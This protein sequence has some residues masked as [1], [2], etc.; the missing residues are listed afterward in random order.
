V[1][2]DVCLQ[3]RRV[4]ISNFM[5]W[6]ISISVQ[7]GLEDDLLN[8]SSRSRSLMTETSCRVYKLY[9]VK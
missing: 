5:N 1:C 3:V 7:D 9:Q 8:T 4:M 6:H 2:R